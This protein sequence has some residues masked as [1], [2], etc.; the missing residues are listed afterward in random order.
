MDIYGIRSFGVKVLP[1]DLGLFLHERPAAY[2]KDGMPCLPPSYKMPS[3]T[4][5]ER[6]T[7]MEIGP[8]VMG[9]TA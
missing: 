2:P 4:S 8:C 3:Q 1:Q 7:L 9:I 6:M 5:I